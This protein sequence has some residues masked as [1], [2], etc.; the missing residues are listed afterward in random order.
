M[1]PKNKHAVALA[2]MRKGVKEKPSLL[3]AEL[4]RKNLAKARE[5]RWKKLKPLDKS[6]KSK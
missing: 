6:K 2:K 4:A 1:S 3:K 5:L